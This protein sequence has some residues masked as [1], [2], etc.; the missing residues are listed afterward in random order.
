MMDIATIL[1]Y[2]IIVADYLIVGYVGYVVGGE[3]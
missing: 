1:L 2:C 3:G